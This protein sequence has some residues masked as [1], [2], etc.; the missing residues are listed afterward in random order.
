MVRFLRAIARYLKE[1]FFR[2]VILT[3][4]GLGAGCIYLVARSIPN[5]ISGDG[6]TEYAAGLAVFLIWVVIYQNMF[7]IFEDRGYV[8]GLRD[9]VRDSKTILKKQ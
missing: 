8:T 4:A 7:D 6:P 2:S 9:L 1:T 3:I 5:F